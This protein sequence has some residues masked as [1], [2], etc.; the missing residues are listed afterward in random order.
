APL[1]RLDDNG[2]GGESG[3]D[4]I[5]RREPPRR[6]LHTGRVLGQDQSRLRDA[7]REIGVRGGVVA[8]DAATEDRDGGAFGVERAA[9]R[10]AV[11]AT[12]ETADDDEAC[13]RELAREAP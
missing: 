5:A 8:V 11:D 9:V 7:S 1:A 6:R 2:D 3:D 12:R 4:A 13:G 10:L